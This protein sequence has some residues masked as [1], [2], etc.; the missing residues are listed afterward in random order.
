MPN[1]REPYLTT[2]PWHLFTLR[3]R[4]RPAPLR[5]CPSA[6]C[7]RAKA[8]LD[9]HDQIYCQRSHES[10]AERRAKRGSRGLE[11]QAARPAAAWTLDEITAKREESDLMLAAA[12]AREREMTK[13]W[14]AGEFD[15]LYGKYK[16]HGVLKHPP[17]RQYTE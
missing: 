2:T 14:K 13:R 3:E 5:R 9:A 8:C 15:D 1:P 16:P 12:Q 6:K 11:P 17:S 4:K 7:R 10:V